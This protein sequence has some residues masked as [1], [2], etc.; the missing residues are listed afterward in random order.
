[1]QRQ[2]L[3]ATAGQQPSADRNGT[4]AGSDGQEG[5]DRGRLGA[6]LCWAVV[7]ADIGTSVYYTPGILFGQSGVGT[8]RSSWGSH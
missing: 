3:A 4:A 5:G 8:P 2:D 7:F 6:F 1:M